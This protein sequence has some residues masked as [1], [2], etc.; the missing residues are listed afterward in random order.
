MN[1]SRKRAAH[2]VLYNICWFVCTLFVDADVHAVIVY[3]TY[4]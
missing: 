3:Y 4:W 1:R 2:L